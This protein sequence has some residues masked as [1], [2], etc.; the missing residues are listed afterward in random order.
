MNPDPSYLWPG[1][2]TRSASF[3]NPTAARSGGGTAFGGRKG[4]P[5]RVLRPGDRVVLAELEGPGRLTHLWMT[6]AP[7]ADAPLPPVLRAQVLE[8]FYDGLAEPSVSVP[9]C[10]Y[11]GAVHGV[12]APY[13]SAVTVA[14]EGRG[15]ASRAPMPFADALRLEY[16]NASAVPVI[17][18][19]QADF[20]IGAVPDGTGFLH[21]SFRR[22]NPTTLGED[23]T[24]VDGL[25]GRG[26][27]F[28]WTGG[29]RTLD[30]K[31]WW[32]EGEVKLYLDGETQ[33]TICGTGTEDH[34]D[35]AWGLGEFAAPESGA[36]LVVGDG[37]GSR[38]HHRLIS[39]YR[40]HLSDPVLFDQS[41]RVTVQQ[42]GA[43]LFGLGS[44]GEYEAFKQQVTPAGMGWLEGV[45]PG[46]HAFGLYERADD[47]CATSF[48]YCAQPQ[49]VPRLKLAVATADLDV[50]IRSVSPTQG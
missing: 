6:V 42:I 28:G 31:R 43:A 7:L 16:E 2:E 12:P 37:S 47:W 1:Y 23:F 5:N 18:Y 48:V 35:S 14:N 32:G 46:Q 3:E 29:V 4:A 45:V 8:A 17:L 38:D 21:S 25:D 13:A 10:D 22:E 26:R 36:P 40:W 34:L 30:D 24:I 33:P 27:L 11:F 20:L 9:A 49:F 15:W 39:F 44:E 19:Y 50:A 41:L